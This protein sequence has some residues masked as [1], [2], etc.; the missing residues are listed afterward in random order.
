MNNIFDYTWK[1]WLTVLFVPVI[2]VFMYLGLAT[3]LNDAEFYCSRP[4]NLCTAK[5]TNMFGNTITT[6]VPLSDVVSASSEAFHDTHTRH[7]HYGLAVLTS[8]TTTTTYNLYINCKNNESILL[9]G[10]IDPWSPKPKFAMYK[11][12][13][14]INSFLTDSKQNEIKIN[15]KGFSIDIWSI[16]TCYFG[17]VI[18]LIIVLVIAGSIGGRNNP[19]NK[20]VFRRT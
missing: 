16:M 5:N 12:I 13:D 7:K 9:Y 14:R 4:A 19:L 11:N 15:Y 2:V 6:E 20:F 8:S 10:I 17:S 18:G 3:Y 1:F